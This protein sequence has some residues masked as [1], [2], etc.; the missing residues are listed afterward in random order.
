MSYCAIQSNEEYIAS[1]L[2]AKSGCMLSNVN[3]T[4][5][6]PP[7]TLICNYA[8]NYHHYPYH[9]HPMEQ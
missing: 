4:I 8:I 3:V 6:V 1:Q 2:P 9:Y 7:S 5:I